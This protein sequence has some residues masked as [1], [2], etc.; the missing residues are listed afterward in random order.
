MKDYYQVLGVPANAS[1][2]DIKKAFRKLAFRY[3]PDTNRGNEKAAEEKFKE[4]N[5][6]FG[7]L[8]DPEKRRQYDLARQSGAAYPPGQFGYSQEDIFQGIFANQA[9]LD[10]LTRMFAQAGLRFDR[11]F[12]NRVYFGGRGFTIQFFTSTGG[13]A[14]QAGNAP[15]NMPAQPGLAYKPGII[16]RSATWLIRK[17]L[18]VVL[19]V[20]GYPIAAPQKDLDQH[21]EFEITAAEAAAGGE[22]PFTYRRGRETRNLMVK[23]PP[24]I[25]SGTRIRLKGLGKVQGARAGDLYLHV[26]VKR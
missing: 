8:G 16:E 21:V 11:D 10:E 19:R 7:V 1:P 14:F 26:K 9:M 6:A 12:L 5:E 24:G 3:H 15:G 13:R 20:F 23:I 2:E 25:A 17:L 18:R 22:K 4:I